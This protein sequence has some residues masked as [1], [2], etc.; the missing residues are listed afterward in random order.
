MKMDYSVRVVV[1]CLVLA[2]IGAMEVQ[3]QKPK[4]LPPLRGLSGMRS[5][6]ES[7]P[8]IQVESRVRL[9]AQQQKGVLD[10]RVSLQGN[11]HIYSTTQQPGGPTKTTIRVVK[12]PAFEVV[13]EFVP[14]KKPHR[15]KSDVFDVDEEYHQKMVVWSAPIRMLTKV[16]PATFAIQGEVGGQICTDGACIPLETIDTSFKAKIDPQAVLQA[17]SNATPGGLGAATVASFDWSVM[18]KNMWL[19]LV[20][21]LV[22]NLMPCVLPVIGLKLMS[23]IEQSHGS[24]WEAFR[25]NLFYTAGILFVFAILASMIVFMGANWGEQFTHTGFKVGMVLLVF[26]MAL[27][28]LGVWEIPIP[29]FVGR[30][31]S[32]ELAEKEGASGAFFKGVF[33][34]ILATPCSGPFLGAVFAYTAKQAPPVTYAIFLS[35]GLGLSLPYIIIGAFPSLLRWIP[36]PGA[37]ME[38]F[39]ESMGFVLLGT[40]VYLISAI[41]DK[42][43]I[44]VLTTMF[45]V[46]F[47][48][49]WIGRTP[50]SATFSRKMV[51]WV[52]GVAAA[53][54]ISG[55]AFNYLV[56]K[57]HLDWVPYS[58]LA[59]QEAQQEGKTVLVDF[60][61][62][63]C[64]ICQRNTRFAIDTARVERVVDELGVVPLLAD[65]SDKSQE[66][67][68]KLTDLDS[69]SIPLLAIYPAGGSGEPIVLRDLVRERDVIEALRRAGPSMETTA[70]GSRSRQAPFS[71]AKES[72]VKAHSSRLPSVEDSSRRQVSLRKPLS[73]SHE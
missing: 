73:P 18:M 67:K 8:P 59:L 50:I 35:V 13:G 19:G 22:L 27:S 52:S 24:R 1:G 61:A 28:F 4:S 32:Q 49:W 68:D 2:T 63:W 15:V 5:A 57:H 31:K 9:D 40:T 29:G 47:G 30:G 6:A 44:P 14:D 71:K 70:A 7:G 45:G 21:G 39:K 55:F 41:N 51:N 53:V 65:W 62:D 34:T 33:T 10:V 16:D 42:L 37:W 36:K 66:I 17:S 11:Y 60:T 72:G 38:T 20:G 12:N 46:W 3:A 48:C 56:A 69:I 54:L 26:A 58:E 23:F 43:F 25:L 64:L